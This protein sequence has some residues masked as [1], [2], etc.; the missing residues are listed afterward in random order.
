MRP[1][2]TMRL[3]PLLHRLVLCP[4]CT[5]RLARPIVVVGRLVAAPSAMTSLA[6]QGA[7]VRLHGSPVAAP[8]AAV[9]VAHL[10]SG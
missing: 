10:A 3:L 9:A 7:V 8:V 2:M 6:A 1:K 4:L 5:V